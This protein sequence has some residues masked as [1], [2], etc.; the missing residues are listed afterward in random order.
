MA[1]DD[2]QSTG[3]LGESRSGDKA[4]CCDGGEV[5]GTGESGDETASKK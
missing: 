2:F 3:R 5:Q 1:I 4:I